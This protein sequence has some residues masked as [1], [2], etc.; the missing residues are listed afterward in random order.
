MAESITARP[1]DPGSYFNSDS[2][3][4]MVIVFVVAGFVIV[5]RLAAQHWYSEPISTSIVITTIT[6]LLPP[7]PLHH[8]TPRPRSTR[9]LLAPGRIVVDVL[10]CCYSD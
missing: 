3:F 2:K 7:P 10:A 5:R 4:A 6:A 1:I 8:R 9:H